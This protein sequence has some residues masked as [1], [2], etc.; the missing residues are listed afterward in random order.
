MPFEL[1]IVYRL[2]SPLPGI[3]PKISLTV[4]MDLFVGDEL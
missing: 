1:L 4:F 3:C 2:A